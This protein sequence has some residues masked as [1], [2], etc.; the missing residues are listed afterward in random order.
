MMSAFNPIRKS[1]FQLEI[2]S[3]ASRTGW[4]AYSKGERETNEFWNKTDQQLHINALE[5]LAVFFGLKVLLRN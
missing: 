5:L 4:G 2:F 3:G 1:R